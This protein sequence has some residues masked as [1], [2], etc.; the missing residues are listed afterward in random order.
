MSVPSHGTNPELTHIFNVP[1]GPRFDDSTCYP[2]VRHRYFLYALLNNAY[3]L[4]TF[5]CRYVDLER[6]TSSLL[7]R[8]V[9]P[10]ILEASCLCVLLIPPSGSAIVRRTS[11]NSFR[12]R[13]VL[14]VSLRCLEA[15]L[16]RYTSSVNLATASSNFSS[17][18]RASRLSQANFSPTSGKES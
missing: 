15:V 16:S 2:H 8:L 3:I 18:S 1:E 17:Q 10:R 4:K 5:S 14:P 13:A 9:L 11:L 12:F 6:F 7:L